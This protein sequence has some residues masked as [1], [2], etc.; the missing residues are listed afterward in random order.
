MWWSTDGDETKVVEIY[1]EEICLF[2]QNANNSITTHLHGNPVSLFRAHSQGY[3]AKVNR[4]GFVFDN[5]N[6]I[7][8][9]EMM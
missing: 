8:F 7:V 9:H 4:S 5:S 1:A 3:W 6:L 2:V